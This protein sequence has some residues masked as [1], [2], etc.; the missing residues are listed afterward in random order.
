MSTLPSMRLDPTVQNGKIPE[1]MYAAPRDRPQS[2][3]HASAPRSALARDDNSTIPERYKN[4]SRDRRPYLC[5]QSALRIGLM[6]ALA[7]LYAT[8]HPY[9]SY[10]LI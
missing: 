10:M 5:A 6:T 3:P 2:V 9:T 1:E 4:S 8:T 7:W